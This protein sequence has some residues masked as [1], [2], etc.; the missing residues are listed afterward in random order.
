MSEWSRLARELRKRRDERAPVALATVVSTEGSAY[1]RAGAWMLVSPDG[2]R[3]G[4]VS[5]GCLEADV[6]ERALRSLASGEIEL[7]EYD[8][9]EQDDLVWGPGTGCRGLVRILIEPLAGDRL[10]QAAE[11]FSRV[12]NVSAEA[13]IAVA[14]SDV[15][16]ESRRMGDRAL[17]A[18]DSASTISGDADRALIPVLPVPRLVVC[19]AGDDAVPL[20]Q[21]AV[22]LDWRVVVF[23]HRPA[24]ARPERFPGAQVE[25]VENSSALATLME[26]RCAGPRTAA[27]VMTHN[28]QRDVAWTAALLPLELRYLGLLG[29]RRRGEQVVA[30]AAAL[31]TAPSRVRETFAP[32]GIDIA[33]ESPREI[34][35]AIV[36]EISGVLGGGTLGHLRDSRRE[37]ISV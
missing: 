22:D 12:E 14:L 26:E 7:A 37:T 4:I 23:D 17:V 30:A 34:A 1:R 2:S 35:L 20:V 13:S 21:L 19:G 9:R 10:Q 36:A 27:V 29:P 18:A 3:E 16:A 28:L 31:A 11:F 25:L 24:F 33:S 15:P 6:A 8:T 5:G 32:V